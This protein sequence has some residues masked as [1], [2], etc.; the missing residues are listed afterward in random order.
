MHILDMEKAY[1]KVCREEFWWLLYES[2]IEEYL[3]KGIKSIYEGSRT[4]VR[5]GRRMGICFEANRK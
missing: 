4:C 5:G 3:F 2:G 1:D